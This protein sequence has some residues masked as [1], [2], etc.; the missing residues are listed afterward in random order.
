ML[1]HC[2]RLLAGRWW[3]RKVKLREILILQTK[4][5]RRSIFAN[6][7]GV[8]GARDCADAIRPQ[9]P[10]ERDLGACRAGMPSRHGMKYRMSQDSALLDR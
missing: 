9:H 6:M 2:Q 5:Q 8:T 7:G 4:V 10:G 1:G 3:E